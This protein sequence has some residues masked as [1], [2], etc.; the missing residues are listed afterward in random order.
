[1][2]HRLDFRWRVG[3]DLKKYFCGKATVVIIFFLVAERTLATVL[4]VT[5]MF[6][7]WSGGGEVSRCFYSSLSGS[8]KSQEARRRIYKMIRIENRCIL[9]SSY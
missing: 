3:K 1:M 8:M 2:P 5:R 4:Q 9:E 7:W 6:G